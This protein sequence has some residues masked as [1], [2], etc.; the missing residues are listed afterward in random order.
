MRIKKGGI[1][2]IHSLYVKI[3]IASNTKSVPAILDTGSEISLI[4]SSLVKRLN[5]TSRKTQ[6]WRTIC[7]VGGKTLSSYSNI[8][9]YF[10]FLSSENQHNDEQKLPISL[11]VIDRE[12]SELLVLGIDILKSYQLLIDFRGMYSEIPSLMSDPLAN[13][14]T[15]TM[16]IS[17]PLYTM[18]TSE[19]NSLLQWNSTANK[20]CPFII[21]FVEQ[22]EIKTQALCDTGS[23]TSIITQDL[24]ERMGLENEI[25]KPTREIMLQGIAGDPISALGTI[26]LSLKLASSGK[27]LTGK[28]VVIEGSDPIA[29]ILGLDLLTRY[30]LYI[31]HP[32]GV[33]SNG[34]DIVETLHCL[35]EKPYYSYK[36]KYYDKTL[37]EA[38]RLIKMALKKAYKQLYYTQRVQ[39]GKINRGKTI[40]RC[41]KQWKN[42]HKLKTL[43]KLYET[44]K[45]EFLQ[46]MKEPS[47]ETKSK[48]T[49][50]NSDQTDSE[51]SNF[52]L[53]I[54]LETVNHNPKNETRKPEFDQHWKL[55][56]MSKNTLPPAKET[57]LWV[58]L[59]PRLIDEFNNE[60]ALFEPLR[61]N[62]KCIHVGP[63]VIK[64]N[65]QIA[66]TIL[67]IND[68]PTRLPNNTI[69]GKVTPLHENHILGTLK[70]DDQTSMFT[71]QVLNRTVQPATEQNESE[72][73]EK[74]EEIINSNPWMK[75][76][77]V[78]AK[79]TPHQK[80]QIFQLINN[81][82]QVFST[83]TYDLGH[84]NELEFEIETTNVTPITVPPYRLPYEKK[85]IL[86]KLIPE[87]IQ[88]GII[89]P[90]TSRY[91][92]PV[93]LI[94]KK[95]GDYRLCLDMRRLNDVTIAENLPI[96][97]IGECLDVLR[98]KNFFSSLDLNSAYHQI[99]IRKEDRQ[100]TGFVANGKKYQ[101]S[102]MLFGAK[103]A[104]FYWSHLMEKVL[105]PMN[106]L[107]LLIYLDDILV[108]SKGFETHLGR[109]EETF[110]RLL[111][112]NLKLKPGKCSFAHSQTKFL[113]FIVSRNGLV[114]N[115][116]KVMA[117]TKLEAPRN[118]KGVQ[119]FLGLL[120]YYSRWLENW[121]K[122]ALPITQL[123]RKNTPFKW[124]HNCQ[125]SFNILKTQLCNP[126]II[127]GPDFSK[128]FIV[129]CD[130]SLSSSGAALAQQDNSGDEYVIGFFSKKFTPTEY[131]YGA[132][133]KELLSML[134]AIDFFKAYLWGRKF[135]VRTDCKALTHFQNLKVTSARHARWRTML[136]E[137]NFTVQHVAGKDHVEAD[138]LS[139][140]PQNEWRV[141]IFKNPKTVIYMSENVDI[142]EVNCWKSDVMA[143]LKLQPEHKQTDKVQKIMNTTRMS[144]FQEVSRAIGGNT[145]Y[146]LAI[147]KSLKEYIFKHKNFYSENFDGITE[148][149]DNLSNQITPTTIELTAMASM[150]KIPI[151]VK[152][153]HRNRIFLPVT[154]T[155]VNKLPPLGSVLIF[156]CSKEGVY[157]WENPDYNNNTGEEL[158]EEMLEGD[159]E[160]GPDEEIEPWVT[161]QNVTLEAAGFHDLARREKD[162]RSLCIKPYLT[163]EPT[164]KWPNEEK[165]TVCHS[166]KAIT[167]PET[168]KNLQLPNE[169]DIITLQKGDLYCQG[170]R[171]YIE[172]KKN[173]YF[174]KGHLEKFQHNMYI[175]ENGILLYRKR[176]LRKRD[177]DDQRSL[178]VLPLSM[179]KSVL[180][181]AHDR[182]GHFGHNKV[183]QLLN[184]RY[185]RQKPSLQSI[186]KDY[187][188]ACL[189]CKNKVGINEPKMAEIQPNYLPEDRFVAWSIDH[190]KICKSAQG[191][192]Y[193][194][195]M[196]DLYT[197]FAMTWPVPDTGVKSAVQAIMINIVRVFGLPDVLLSDRGAAF[198]SEIYEH[199]TK[200]LNITIKRTTAF[201]P[202][203]NG[204]VERFNR[205]LGDMI[206]TAGL[207]EPL[208]WEES[209]PILTLSY[210]TSV[211]R[212]LGETP[213]YLMF[214]K[215]PKLPL[216]L[217]VERKIDHPYAMG[218]DNNFSPSAELQARLQNAR[219]IAQNN[220]M[221]NL[222]KTREEANINRITREFQVGDKVLLKVPQKKGERKKFH[223]K[224]KGIFRIENVIN[225]V[226]VI[227][228]SIT[229]RGKS[230]TVHINRIIR[231]DDRKKDDI[232]KW[233]T[234]YDEV[235]KMDQ[236]VQQGTDPEWIDIFLDN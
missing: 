133:D 145:L 217:I 201:H 225:K 71:E 187:I 40:K 167:P 21:T 171:E 91:N 209:L 143:N 178:L 173:P 202:A 216:D 117:I 64:I 39:L 223:L 4:S 15:E 56:T 11:K 142:N 83:S 197:R 122:T 190:V 103:N 128:M 45:N 141:D 62:N 195:T 57:I 199:I 196:C 189:A 87:M 228:K 31:R 206:R 43:V 38:S 135:V 131:R 184:E 121:Q 149:P 60:N 224:Y 118:L 102:K 165:N 33:L 110:Q 2:D 37:Y 75:E 47:P 93:V 67:N 164:A 85:Q 78:S 175:D 73:S 232:I 88:A 214:A 233:S 107:R 96:P 13:I 218:Q 176:N 24:V 116:V 28:F 23:Y 26:F 198:T 146:T 52:P 182:N 115:P 148:R 231:F 236:N 51:D 69:L 97:N 100:K 92:N 211:N 12:P 86:K 54:T 234:T 77:S 161:D 119:R 153:N 125:Q 137:Y 180:I 49:K 124:D 139:R 172:N 159:E 101:Y 134:R 3:K 212:T 104:P 177:K 154:E 204:A 59:P 81:Y 123:L 152:S 188:Q 20:S 109:L 112:A 72:A 6:D 221:K 132:S 14:P 80:L 44:N 1:E 41:I 42:M 213:A 120:N 227:I 22:S 147:K 108:F 35:D 192:E 50:C 127:R 79:L 226:N 129:S 48:I 113:G 105:G 74:I 65:K 160:S 183:T 179:A 222:E 98:G 174:G 19:K 205:S 95:T 191:N 46:I 186:A 10:N 208:L 207:K 138:F 169:S 9:T 55:R 210:N 140:S 63:Q 229:G 61:I 90:S 25:K 230:Q 30:N 150:I 99:S 18:R 156:S 194:L 58:S 5:L 16:H 8:N 17:T 34:T 66:L 163:E 166:Y 151:I 7:G 84:T 89:E 29:L 114:P 111:S 215:D 158:L 106:F 136:G 70:E 181:M 82:Q 155:I 32:S 170:W 203:C 126:P 219:T 53:N 193:A 162:I 168:R 200:L 185:F 68:K 36:L 157:N 220:I 94:K 130:A 27:I 76:I 144:L 235:V